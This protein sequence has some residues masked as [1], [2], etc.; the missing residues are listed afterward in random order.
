MVKM[1]T[2]IYYYYTIEAG[3]LDRTYTIEFCHDQKEEI[4]EVLQKTFNAAK[5]ALTFL[6]RERE[7]VRSMI[8]AYVT[9]E[10]SNIQS[11]SLRSGDYLE[12]LSLLVTFEDNEN[13]RFANE[14]NIQEIKKLSTILK[15]P[16]KIQL[17][18]E[19]S[20]DSWK[21]TT[22][23]G[24]K[25][26]NDTILISVFER[27]KNKTLFD[28]EINQTN[29]TTRHKVSSQTFKMTSFEEHLSKI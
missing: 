19:D 14:S 1:M 22:Y 18:H 9:N 11:N 28:L 5:Q 4:D 21:N 10:R 26:T 7:K 3:D 27:S 15:N 24:L 20:T 25:Q 13:D 8:S 12:L 6:S 23:L 29:M 17:K 2:P 16:P